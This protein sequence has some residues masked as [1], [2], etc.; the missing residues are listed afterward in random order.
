MCSTTHVENSTSSKVND[1]QVTSDEWSLLLE[2]NQFELL[3]TLVVPPR[4]ITLFARTWIWDIL[5]QIESCGEILRTIIYCR[6]SKLCM[7]FVCLPMNKISWEQSGLFLS[8]PQISLFQNLATLTATFLI[9]ILIVSHLDSFNA[10]M[11][12]H[13]LS[14]LKAVLC[15]VIRLIFQK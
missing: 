9:Q 14:L 11:I 5:I 15:S 3:L 12:V 1:Q 2:I 7:Y 6:I 4:L 13:F 10:Y 8:Y